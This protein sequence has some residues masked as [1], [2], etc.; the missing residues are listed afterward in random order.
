MRMLAQMHEECGGS[1]K[2]AEPAVDTSKM[3]QYDRGEYETAMLMKKIREG[4]VAMEEINQKGGSPTERIKI[5]NAV[6]QQHQ[7]LQREGRE[8]KEAAR[9][10]NK[11]DQ[12]EQLMFHVNKTHDLYRSRDKKRTADGGEGDRLAGGGGGYST[13][14]GGD[15]G[16]GGGGTGFHEMKNVP[17]VSIMEDQE[18]QQYMTQIRQKDQQMDAALDVIASGLQRLNQTAKNIGTELKKQD[19]LLNNIDT[20]VDEAQEELNTMNK[21]MNKIVNSVKRDA[22]CMY[23]ICFLLI[24]GIIGAIIAVIKV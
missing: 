17:T 22:C 19:V 21:R 9:K 15:S 23:I 7:Q 11:I 3:S 24:L 6:R 8:L 10:E 4:I 20:A 5:S 2:E 1:G 13:F 14:G 12:Y 16:G 18:F